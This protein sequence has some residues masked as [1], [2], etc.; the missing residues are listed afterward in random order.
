MMN[1]LLTRKEKAIL[2]LVSNGFSNKEISEFEKITLDTVKWHLK[3]VYG[4][5]GVN[6]RTQAVAKAIKMK[7]IGW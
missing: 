5:L 7:G 3:N 6:R 4:K 2:K 1:M